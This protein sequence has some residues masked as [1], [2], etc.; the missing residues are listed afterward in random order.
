MHID[1]QD[2]QVIRRWSTGQASPADLVLAGVGGDA[3]A[4]LARFCDEMKTLVPAVR[5][6]AATEDAFRAPAIIIGSHQNIAYQA[7][8]SGRELP[9][10]LEAVSAAAAPKSTIPQER[11]EL[12]AQLALFVAMECP[13]CP[14]VVSRLLPLA[15]VHPQL[16]LIVIDAFLFPDQAEAR[17]IR[18]VPTLILDD[19]LRWTGSIDI[20]EVVR[21]CVHRDPA[22]LSTASLQQ[23]VETGQAAQLSALMGSSG[24]IFPAFLDL[25]I[26]PT[27]S[28]RLGALVTA[29]CLAA[30]SP[31]LAAQL[32][33]PLWERFVGLPEQVQGDLV[34]VLAQVKEDAARRHLEEIA[35][36]DFAPSVQEAAREELEDSSW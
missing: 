26:H 21:Q 19:Q 30:E 12:P 6:R 33:E 9:P 17:D 11:I 2:A 14:L 8:P 22:G 24:R 28:V 25:L 10:F 18:S 23:L 16:R 34:Q 27:W 7:V 36:G 35:S 1:P 32:V 13:N 31:E 5:V 15:E 3:G 29:E 20:A 4:A